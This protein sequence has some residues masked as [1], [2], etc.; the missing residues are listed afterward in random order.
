MF[1]FRTR[2]L[3]RSSKRPRG[4]HNAKRQGRLS[5]P[6]SGGYVSRLLR[7]VILGQSTIPL[8]V[9]SGDKHPMQHF[10]FYPSAPAAHPRA[11]GTTPRIGR[12]GGRRP[13][14]IVFPNGL[15]DLS[16]VGAAL[17]GV[18][19]RALVQ[20]GG[21]FMTRCEARRMSHSWRFS[22][23]ARFITTTVLAICFIYTQREGTER[24]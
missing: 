12:G 15:P 9:I 16:T 11:T 14:K 5:N 18:V 1:T 23:D 4:F 22:T 2:I 8:S 3:L 19:G 13:H 20:G 10:A 6:A 24:S 17:G 7:P 21:F